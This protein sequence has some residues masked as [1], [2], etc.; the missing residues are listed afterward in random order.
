MRIGQSIYFYTILALGLAVS[1]LAGLAIYAAA[2]HAHGAHGTVAA[3]SQIR[4]H[5]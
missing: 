2:G 3:A 1:L 5:A 4:Y